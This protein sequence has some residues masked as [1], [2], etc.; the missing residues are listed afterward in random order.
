[1]IGRFCPACNNGQCKGGGNKACIRRVPA[2]SVIVGVLD[3][4]GGLRVV[5]THRKSVRHHVKAD[6]LG[7]VVPHLR[8]HE[9]IAWGDIPTVIQRAELEIDKWIARGIPND[10]L[11]REIVTMYRLRRSEHPSSRGS[12]DLTK[13]VYT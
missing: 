5:V 1:L 8:V 6:E 3:T 12:L 7:I 13:L 2:P 4:Y 10:P 9:P 11:H